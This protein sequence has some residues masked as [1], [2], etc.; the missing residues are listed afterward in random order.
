MLT[1]SREIVRKEINIGKKNYEHSAFTPYALRCDEVLGDEAQDYDLTYNDENVP[2]NQ[3]M[4]E[5]N[6]TTTS[7]KVLTCSRAVHR[8]NIKIGKNVNRSAFTPFKLKC[9]EVLNDFD[10]TSNNENV[11]PTKKP[12]KN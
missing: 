5:I 10:S 2:P 3:F 7:G 6:V 4:E 1:C 11:H 9:L 8:E 12:K